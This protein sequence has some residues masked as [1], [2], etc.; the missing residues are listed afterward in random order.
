MTYAIGFGDIARVQ[1]SLYG[2]INSRITHCIK[3]YYI[4]IYL[5]LYLSKIL[6]TIRFI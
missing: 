1:E 6:Q 3:L 2:L 5:N 4:K